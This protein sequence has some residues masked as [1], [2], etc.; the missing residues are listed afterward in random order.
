MITVWYVFEFDGPVAIFINRY[1][2]GV[3]FVA[4]QGNGDGL[5]RL[6]LAADLNSLAVD[7]LAFG[8]SLDNYVS[9]LGS[10]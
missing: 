10:I 8:R 9:F 3:F 7:G 5:I 4:V 6:T 1:S 2:L